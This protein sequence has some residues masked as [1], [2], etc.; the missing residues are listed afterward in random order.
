MSSKIQKYVKK[1][2]P[3]EAV[4]LEKV[5]TIKTLEGTMK[6]KKGDYLVTGIRG[7]KYIVKRDI[8]EEMY[9]LFQTKET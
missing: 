1:P 4:Q 6:G 8:F 3:I 9:V 5:K 2:I 7:E